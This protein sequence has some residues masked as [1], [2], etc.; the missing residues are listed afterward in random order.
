LIMY[1]WFGLEEVN[2]LGYYRIH[3]FVFST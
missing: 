1:Q 2:G 3:K